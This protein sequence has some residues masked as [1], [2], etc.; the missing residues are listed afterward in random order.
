M[1][2]NPQVITLDSQ[3]SEG[4]EYSSDVILDEYI[5]SVDFSFIDSGI[6]Y[7]DLL[8]SLNTLTSGNFITGSL[9]NINYKFNCIFNSGIPNATGTQGFINYSYNNDIIG[10]Y[11]TLI[12]GNL[13]ISNY[14]FEE[15]TYLT[16]TTGD[17]Q[18]TPIQLYRIH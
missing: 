6:Y 17:F 5:E 11:S 14:S 1:A 4:C 16:S 12:S 2:N 10:L 15:Y 7:F 18:N 8:N 13:H 9:N 3:W